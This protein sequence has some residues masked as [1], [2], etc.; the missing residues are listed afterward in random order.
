VVVEPGDTLPPGH[1]CADVGMQNGQP[2]AYVCQGATRA[3]P[4]QSP[5]QLSQLLTL[6]QQRVPAA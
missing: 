4:I 2:T 5:V 3:G 1:P 6:P